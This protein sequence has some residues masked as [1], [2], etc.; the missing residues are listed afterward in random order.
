MRLIEATRECRRRVAGLI[1]VMFFTVCGG[2]AAQ[3][4]LFGLAAPPTQIE[5][6]PPHVD[7]VSGTTLARLEQARA[8]VKSH[9]WDEAVAIYQD[10][11]LERTDRVVESNHGRFVSLRTYCNIQLSQ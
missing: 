4:L 1:V 6:D 10:L 2:S 11:A 9:S 3:P 8:L 7:L 5:L